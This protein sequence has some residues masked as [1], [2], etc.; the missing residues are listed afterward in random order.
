VREG[1]LLNYLSVPPAAFR[2]KL[3]FSNNNSERIL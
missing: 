3:K 2:Y 1:L